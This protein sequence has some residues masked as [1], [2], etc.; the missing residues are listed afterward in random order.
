MDQRS[1]DL[2]P[3]PDLQ[4]HHKGT[5]A[6]RHQIPI[7]QDYLPPCND[8]CPAGENTKATPPAATA[9]FAFG[10]K[11]VG[12]KDL[13]LQAISYGNV[14]VAQVAMGANPQQTLLAMRETEAYPGPSLILAYRHSIAHGIQMK[15]GMHQQKLAVETAYWPLNRYNPELR[16]ANHNPFVLDSPKSKRRLEEYAYNE[17]RY[18]IL[19]KTNPKQAARL[20]D[21]AKKMAELKWKTYEDKAMTPA[22]GFKPV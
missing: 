8:R 15:K 9:K 19:T 14:Y 21:L 11:E 3:F 1:S 17:M 16:Q 2:T 20:M 18:K 10:G 4:S 22:S 7:Y 5:G 6:L 12:K 13:A